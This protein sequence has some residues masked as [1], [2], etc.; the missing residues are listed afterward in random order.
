MPSL[1]NGDQA[2][3]L[4]SSNIQDLNTCHLLF[5]VHL[6]QILLTTD[7]FTPPRS[8]S[9]TT[10]QQENC[11]SKFN[12]STNPILDLFH[13]VREAVGFASESDGSEALS[14]EGVWSDL[15]VASLPFLRCAALFYHHL[16]SI[17]AAPE[18][19]KVITDPNEE[20]DQLT[21][22][23]SLPNTP[24]GILESPHLFALS[25]KWANHPNVHIMLSSAAS[26][27]ALPV[28]YPI[29]I[30]S[31]IDLPKDYSELINSV[32]L[33]TCP[34]SRQDESRV[35]AMCLICGQMMCS[36]SYCCQSVIDGGVQ[37]G[38]CTAHAQKLRRR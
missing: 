31:L 24:A 18:L 17:P 26:T 35:P 6:V 20:F 38:A 36:Q 15:K 28:S 30:N 9:K 11:D 34:K 16:S 23:L 1:F 2:A 27:Y 21:K 33:F 8:T 3:P 10:Q 4:P 14:S 19:Q 32:S 22:Y 5:V 29:Q 25:R 12:P 13:I 7:Q 37:V